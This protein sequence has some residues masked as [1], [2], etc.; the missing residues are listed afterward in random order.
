MFAQAFHSIIKDIHLTVKVKTSFGYSTPTTAL[1]RNP[2]HR[3]L[4]FTLT[5][6]NG[7]TGRREEEEPAHKKLQSKA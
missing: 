3:S 7:I 2:T 4:D 5:A 1:V 6:I